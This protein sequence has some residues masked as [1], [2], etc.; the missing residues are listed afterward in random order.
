[1]AGVTVTARSCSNC[2]RI[3]L[4]ERCHL[5][6]YERPDKALEPELRAFVLPF[7]ETAIE[8]RIKRWIPP[9]RRIYARLLELAK[10]H[11]RRP[12]EAENFALRRVELYR[13]TY[14][15]ATDRHYSGPDP[16]PDQ[17]GLFGPEEVE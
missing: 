12:L 5:C 6:G 3:P 9:E 16:G 13:G 17:T 10:P 14:R 4:V 8:A 1:M 2:N 11:A 7:E 15:L